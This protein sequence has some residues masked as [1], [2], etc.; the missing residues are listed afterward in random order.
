M[1]P[2]EAV[3]LLLLNLSK[4]K[5]ETFLLINLRR[6]SERVEVDRM[7]S[8]ELSYS[9]RYNFNLIMN[10]HKLPN[11]FYQIAFQTLIISE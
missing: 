5:I 10:K 9:R 6:E 2:Y 3:S 1:L 4:I 7:T 8:R 11:V